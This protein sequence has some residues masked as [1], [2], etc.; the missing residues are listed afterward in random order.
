MGSHSAAN[1]WRNLESLCGAYSK[2]KMDD[3][4][5]LIQ[6]TRKGSTP[7]SEYLRQKKNWS[8]MLALAGDPYPEAHL[9]ANVL[10]LR[11]TTMVGVEVF[12]HKTLQLP[13]V[14]VSPTVEEPL[15]NLEENDVALVLVRDLLAKSVASMVIQALFATTV[16]LIKCVNLGYSDSYK[17]YKCLSPTGRIYISR[18][19][20]FNE[21]EFP[22]KTC[23]LNN[24]TTPQPVIIHSTS[25]STFPTHYPSPSSN[26]VDSSS[27]D[28]SREASPAV[29]SS[30]PRA[31][32]STVHFDSPSSVLGPDRDND[33]YAHDLQH[34]HSLQ[35]PISGCV[36]PTGTKTGQDIPAEHNVP[37]PSHPMIT[38]EPVSVAEAIKHPGWFKAMNVELYALKSK[39]TWIL[40]PPSDAYNLVGNK[41]VYKIKFNVDGIV[42]RLKARL[43][44]KGFHQRPEINYDETFSP[45]IKK[46]KENFVGKLEKSIYGLKQAPRAWFDKLKETLTAWNFNN[47]RADTSLFFYKD[48]KVIILDLI[49]VDDIIITRNDKS[50]L[51]NF[52]VELNNKFTLKDI[53]PLQ[54]FLGIEAYRN[55]SGLY[56]T[57]TKYIEYIL[58]RVNMAKI[59]IC[60]TPMTVG[61]PLSLTDGKQMENP[62]LYRSTVGALQYFCHTRPD[63]A[64]GVNKLSHFL[65]TLTDTHWSVVKRVLRY[66]Q[67]TKI[68]GLRFS[69]SDRLSITGF[70]DADWACCPDD[71]RSI[72][73]Y[74]VYLGDTLVSWSSKKQVIVSR[75]STES[76]YRAL[77]HVAAEISWV[78]S[79][80][81]ELHF[82][83]PSPSVTWCDNLSASAL[84][85]NPVIPCSN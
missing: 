4:H 43:V 1:Q 35:Q 6:T 8:D 67:G 24:Y 11:P 73:S 44:A 52:I 33:Q 57:Q 5:T 9:V 50:K 82:P 40:V 38:R 80:L 13:V 79:L 75:S 76:E 42:N 25:W 32:S 36:E 22:L 78:E 56:L 59:K 41:W 37:F 47:S 83:F 10:F 3:T 23:F 66:L 84:A 29:S 14:A 61:K 63:I 48:E 30:S 81:N 16:P 62:T 54:Y 28:T 53:G 58:R 7:M 20:V 51:H 71:R 2:S 74:C 34:E 27:T 72:A 17:G 85:A 64:Y 69:C 12:S 39:G 60:P 46:G 19:V 21:L 15:A 55:A 77:A 26:L 70:S 18:D 31:H 68:K 49:Y 45:V 65:Q